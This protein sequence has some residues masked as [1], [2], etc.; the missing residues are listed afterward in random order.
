MMKREN[1]PI[2]IKLILK[3][4]F[5][6]LHLPLN[7][8]T[9]TQIHLIPLTQPPINLRHNFP[10]QLRIFSFLNLMIR[11]SKS[12]ELNSSVLALVRDEE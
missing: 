1:Y 6:L 2:S 10:K 9:P 8:I 7:P 12:V 3:P 5:L 4:L 11:Q